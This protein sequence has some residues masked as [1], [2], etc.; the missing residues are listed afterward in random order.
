MRSVYI[1][2]IFLAVLSALPKTTGAQTAGENYVVTET[3]LDAAGTRSIKSVQYHDGLGRPHVLVSGG[4]NTSGKYVYTMTEYDQCGREGK[5]WLPAVGTTS[6]GT[7]TS[8]EM[9]SLSCSTYNEGGAFTENRYDGIGRVMSSQTAGEAWRSG[10]KGVRTEYVANKANSVRRY[11]L[12]MSGSLIESPV[13][14]YPA[15]EL[16]GERVTDEDG[17]T[18]EVYR[19]LS[20]HVVLERRDGSNDTYY[21]YEKGLIR[22]VIPPLYQNEKRRQASLLYRYKYD[23]YG[24]CIEKTLPGCDPIRYWYDRCGRLAFM[25]DGRMRKSQRYRFFL[26][27]GLSRLVVQGVCSSVPSDVS[28]RYMGVTLQS[29]GSQVAE[30]GYRLGSLAGIDGAEVEIANYYDGYQCL[31]LPAFKGAVSRHGLRKTTSTCVTSL[32]TAQMVSTTDG[33]RTFRVMYYDSKGRCTDV[34]ETALD[35]IMLRTLTSYSFTGK[36]TRISKTVKVN[37]KVLHITTHRMTY[38]GSSDLL[39]KETLQ[40]DSAATIVLHEDYYNTLGQLCQVKSGGKGKLTETYKY[41]VHGWLKRHDCY[42]NYLSG[43]TP[44]FSEVLHYADGSVPCYNGN[45]SAIAYK[46]PDDLNTWK[47]FSYTYDGLDRLTSATY[48]VGED[49]GSVP[50]VDYSETFAYDESGA[51]TEVTRH[52]NHHVSPR[53][54]DKLTLDYRGFRL[55]KVEDKG[56]NSLLNGSFEFRDGAS[57]AVEYTYDGCGAMLSDKNKGIVKVGYDYGG[58][59]RRVQFSNGCVAEYAYAADGRKLRTVHRTAVSGITATD[60]HVLT[61]SETAAVDSTLYVGGFRISNLN[62]GI[63]YHYGNGYLTCSRAGKVTPYFYVRDHLG[64]VRAALTQTGAVRQIT[65]YYAYGT[66]MG[67]VSKGYVIKTDRYTGKELDREAG[68]DL[69]DYGARQYDATVG[70]FTSMDPMCEQY[71]HL[72]PYLYC[73]GNPVR[74][75]DPDGNSIWTKVAKGFVRVGRRVIKNGA[76]ALTQADTYLSTVS[77]FTDAYNTLTDANTSTGEKVLA[78]LSLASEFLPVSVGDVKDAGKVVKKVASSIRPNGGIAS[79]HGGKVHNDKIDKLIK[80]LRNDKNVRNI[81]KNQKQVDIKG[82][83][84]G[85]NRPDIQ[86][87]KNGIHTN[88]EYDTKQSSSDKHKKIIDTNDPDARNKYYRINK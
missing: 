60:V 71:Y 45:I 52:G 17:H 55:K 30:T 2:C 61:A 38:D 46:S 40:I 66:F 62:G 18:T 87:D 86:F 7:V 10:G 14:Y 79:P 78:G 49:L 9:E 57:K 1:H 65:N 68:L 85:N 70:L 25:Q 75:V 76:S 56:S 48:G 4:V 42:D 8:S 88:V 32:L 64:S 29:G 54:T 41:D 37:G 27:D 35:G 24:R 16:T 59:P 67:D 20:G 3:L 34:R 81:R 31:D 73:A 19:D 22:V 33:G 69:Y 36:P 77:D 5:G 80:I 39:T 13:E 26:Y 43:S 6:P 15:R 84:I 23:L 11:K 83:V 82:N 53:V 12:D 50:S 51:P 63:K 21:I 28:S 58:M 47:G 72:N 74:Y 44:S